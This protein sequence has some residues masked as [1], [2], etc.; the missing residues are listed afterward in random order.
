MKTRC[1]API[2][3]QIDRRALSLAALGRYPATSHPVV[4]MLCATRVGSNAYISSK[5]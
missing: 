2:D 1:V 3:R 5:L 4:T